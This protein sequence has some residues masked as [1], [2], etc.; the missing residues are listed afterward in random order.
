[1]GHIDEHTIELFVLRSGKLSEATRADIA[2]HLE[3]CAG[4]R[5]LA[6]TLKEFYGEFGAETR[7]ME[8]SVEHVMERIYPLPSAVRLTPYRPRPSLP[9]GAGGY[10]AILAAATPT[11][12]S[13]TET[14]ATLASEEHKIT[15]R[16]RREGK[17]NAFRLY[18]HTQ[19]PR[20]RKGVV[21]TI[22]GVNAEFPLDESGQV[23]IELPE[24][25]VPK[26]WTE[27]L[28]RTLQTSTGSQID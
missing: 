8:G 22:P 21:V 14:V 26:E 12:S 10:T 20:W 9:S 13:G 5:S 27:V 3:T 25:T 7:T 2:S 11:H 19:D 28:V 24:E 18:L 15:L 1:M 6:D 17:P 16:V 4:C 23:T